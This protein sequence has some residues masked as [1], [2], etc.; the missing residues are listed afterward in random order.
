MWSTEPLSQ[1][2]QQS[3]PF[4]LRSQ[5]AATQWLSLAVFPNLSMADCVVP[6]LPPHPFQAD[7]DVVR[8]AE[9]AD[10]PL[11]PVFFDAATSSWTAAGYSRG[12]RA[13][14]WQLYIEQVRRGVVR[15]GAACGRAGPGRA[16]R[17]GKAR[18]GASR[19]GCRA[20]AALVWLRGL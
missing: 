9:R 7:P 14:P 17:W 10:I 1:R 4:I 20:A 6:R 19:A 16:V 3:A 11:E 8:R 15:C 5:A 2:S 12:D 18:C 13:Q